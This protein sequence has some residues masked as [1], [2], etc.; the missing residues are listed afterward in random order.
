MLLDSHMPNLDGFSVATVIAR[1]PELAGTTIMM[2]SS[3]GLDG[4][5]TRCRS[6]GRHRAPDQAYQAERPARGDLPDAGSERQKDD[7][8]FRESGAAAI[9]LVRSMRVLVAED[10]VVNQRVASALLRKRGHDVT[11][12]GDGRAAVEAIAGG[13]FDVV[14][15]D[16]QMPEMDGFEATTEI[17]KREQ[18]TG[19]PSAHR[20][21]DRT[22][23]E[24]R[25]RS[26]PSRRH[27]WLYQQTPRCEAALLGGRAGRAC[28]GLLPPEGSL[29][30]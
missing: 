3:S 2:L 11:V 12:V 16:V 1:R 10:N 15:M 7:G 13:P 21:D 9:P 27:G 17:R 28:P 14:L 29:A 4:E 30:A 18:T 8:T 24:W 22:R 25:P 26:V 23:D 6:L 20:R 5:A 19:G